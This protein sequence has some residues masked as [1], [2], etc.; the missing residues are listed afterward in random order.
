MSFVD[1]ITKCLYNDGGTY[2]REC[3]SACE[4]HCRDVEVA[5]AACTE[6][7]IPGCQCDSSQLLDD[8]GLCVNKEECTCYDKFMPEGQ[9][10]MLPGE[11]IERAC[12]SW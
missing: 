8:R 9:R 2:Y 7:C 12:Q 6:E 1:P 11:Q 5:D 3:T 4:G 10:V